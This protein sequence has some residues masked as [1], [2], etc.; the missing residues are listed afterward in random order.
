MNVAFN[1]HTVPPLLEYPVGQRDICVYAVVDG[2]LKPA[3]HDRYKT[4]SVS[5]VPSMSSYVT[6]EPA[7]AGPPDHVEIIARLWRRFRIDD[8][9]ELLQDLKC[10][11]A[12]NAASIKG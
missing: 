3:K 6:N 8:V 1:C 12:A 4:A 7:S 5:D 2:H 9:H 10:R 11:K